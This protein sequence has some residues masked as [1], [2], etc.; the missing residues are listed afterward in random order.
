LEHAGLAHGE[1]DGIRGCGDECLDRALQVLNAAE[2][3]P[4]IEKSMVNGNI[5]APPGAGVK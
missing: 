1:L 4:L 2:K 5:E 3:G